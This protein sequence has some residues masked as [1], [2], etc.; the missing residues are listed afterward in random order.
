L[1]IYNPTNKKKTIVLKKEETLNFYAIV[2]ATQLPH[3]QVT[4][5]CINNPPANKWI[6][7]IK[8][9]KRP[10]EWGEIEPR[11]GEVNDPVMYKN[12]I[13]YFCQG[14]YTISSCNDNARCIGVSGWLI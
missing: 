7:K 10:E 3:R 14:G 12:P 4:N 13:N 1:N 9:K 8:N 11:R 2:A 5:C 6:Q